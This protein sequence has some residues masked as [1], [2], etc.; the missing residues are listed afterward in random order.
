MPQLAKALLQIE[1][2][3]ERRF[4]NRPLLNA[5]ATTAQATTIAILRAAEVAPPP[6]I[7]MQPPESPPD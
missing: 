5:E 3:V 7:P 2:A 4:L 1:Q 6:R